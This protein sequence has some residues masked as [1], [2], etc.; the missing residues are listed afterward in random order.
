[1]SQIEKQRLSR[2]RLF[3]LNGFGEGMTDIT[4]DSRS[5][6]IA[7]LRIGP[8]FD[9]A[10]KV[11]A[12]GFI[13]L[14]GV[15]ALIMAPVLILTMWL[16][17]DA[18]SMNKTQKTLSTDQTLAVVAYNLLQYVASA[19]CVYGAF[20]IMRDETMTVGQTVRAVFPRALIFIGVG[21]AYLLLQGAG[22]LLLVVPGLIAASVYSEAYS[23][24]VIE[25]LGVIDSMKRSQYLTKGNRWRLLGLY[26]GV[27]T[28]Q[29]G[30]NLLVSFLGNKSLPPNFVL[31]LQFGWQILS[32]SF[33][34]TLDV[35]VFHDLR[36]GRDGVDVKNLAN[37]FD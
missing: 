29:I 30:A 35:V 33:F 14:I 8:V 2:R 9:R 3:W 25:R 10:F 12:E 15:A 16:G 28:V 26:V 31:L 6:E 24:C 22:L 27:L 21:I 37:V 17:A 7:P 19:A 13:R 4:A 5:A 11:Y 20:R 34:S 1:M 18:L 23:A 32:M 36:M